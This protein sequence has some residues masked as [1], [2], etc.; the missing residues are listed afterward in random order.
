MFE[1]TDQNFDS[2]VLKSEVPVMVDFFAQWCQP[3]KMMLPI[4]TK[5]AAKYEGKLKVGKYD[6]EAG[7]KIAGQY[8]VLSLPTFIIFKEGKVVFNQSGAISQSQLEARIE[9][10]L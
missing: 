4:I 3:C 6:V 7:S 10:Y 9:E 2:E 1:V 5:I 8:G